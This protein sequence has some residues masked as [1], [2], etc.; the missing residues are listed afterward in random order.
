[1]QPIHN[2][3]RDFLGSIKFHILTLF[4][5]SK[6]PNLPTIIKI[7]SIFTVSYFLS[8]IDLIPDILPIIGQ[9]D[10]AIIVPALIFLIYKI[11]PSD[12]I[13]QSQLKAKNSVFNLAKLP[14][15]GAVIIAIWIIVLIL[16]LKLIFK[17]WEK[18]YWL[19]IE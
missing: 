7:L 16:I 9:L 6:S 19:E 8:P 4:F 11:S 2:V 13:T 18:N 14:I 15:V 3:L 5:L 1:M 17:F 10:D 12:L